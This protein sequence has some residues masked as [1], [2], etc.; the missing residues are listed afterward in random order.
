ML[1]RTRFVYRARDIP[2]V[3]IAYLWG[4]LTRTAS[5][6]HLLRDVVVRTSDGFR[7]HWGRHEDM[8]GLLIMG[9]EKEAFDKLASVFPRGGVFVDVGASVGLYTVRFGAMS[10]HAYSLEPNP[11]LFEILEKDIRLNRLEGRVD[12][13]PVA[14]WGSVARI[15]ILGFENFVP[16]TKIIQVE[17]NT[18][19]NL[20]PDQHPDLV[21]IDVEGAELEVI[22]GMKL[23]RPRY[24]FVEVHGSYGVN[25]AE[26]D[27]ELRAKG[28]TRVWSRPRG[29]QT[30]VLYQW[31]SVQPAQGASQGRETAPR[32]N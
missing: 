30:H 26:I 27:S 11:R 10:S 3:L 12:A 7:W 19:D 2:V 28:Y 1:R 5:T 22:R 14:A 21:K 15:G 18:L 20:V 31:T 25:G 29:G 32:G 23:S 16:S 8:I 9:Y 24:V 13:K 17:T 4:A 6:R